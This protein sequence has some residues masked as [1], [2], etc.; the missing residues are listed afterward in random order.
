MEDILR[1]DRR[2]I[3][4]RK[5]CKSFATSSTFRVRPEVSSGAEME[6]SSGAEMEVSSGVEMEVSS[7]VR[8]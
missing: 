6:V 4:E 7:E 3:R 8:N 5:P 2:S 1:S